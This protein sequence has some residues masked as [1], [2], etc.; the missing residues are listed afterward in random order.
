[1]TN[2]DFLARTRLLIGNDGVSAVQRQ[3]VIV[4][5]VGGVGSWCA[6]SLVR[7]GIT[8]LTIVDSDAVC[9]SN[10]NRQLMATTA[11]IGQPKVEVLRERLQTINPDAEITA[12][13]GRYNADTA[14][15][16]RLEEYD[17]VIDAIDSI[18]DKLDL[19]L[20]ALHTP[21]PTLFSSMG[22][23]RKMDPLQVRVSEFW[24]VDGCPL[25]ATLR[26]RMRKQLRFPERKFKCVW[27]PERNETAEPKGTMMPVTATFGLTL[28]CLVLKD[29]QL[30]CSSDLNGRVQPRK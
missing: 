7:S 17:Y 18:Q 16:F 5:G 24:K 8:H 27:S 10:I 26:K 25:A 12:I 21:H 11:T 19:I 14:E 29:I 15:R 23:A 3:R 28:A 6:E 1:M 2:N 30:H 9:E 4:F 20:L 22:A 13:C